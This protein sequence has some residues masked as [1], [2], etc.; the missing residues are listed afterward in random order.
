VRFEASVTTNMT[1]VFAN[2][3]CKDNQEIIHFKDDLE[4]TEL[5]GYNQSE[6]PTFHLIRTAQGIDYTAGTYACKYHVVLTLSTF[7]FSWMAYVW[8]FMRYLYRETTANC[9]FERLQSWSANGDPFRCSIAS[10]IIEWILIFLTVTLFGCT[11]IFLGSI[12]YEMESKRILP[13]VVASIV[14]TFFL[15]AGPVFLALP[16]KTVMFL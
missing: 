7:I 10:F 15:V 1:D 4:T 2:C 13:H 8:T 5:K 14:L 11:L 9:S 16:T 6:K 3:G 12:G